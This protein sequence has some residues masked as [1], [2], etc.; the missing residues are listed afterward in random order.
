MK[1]KN[2]YS[3]V[4]QKTAN[5]DL[6]YVSY[7]HN[8]NY[9]NFWFSVAFDKKGE[10]CS[11]STMQKMVSDTGDFYVNDIAGN[12]TEREFN[13]ALFKT[14]AFMIKR[15]YSIFVHNNFIEK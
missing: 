10:V 11:I 2:K 13:E 5:S 4:V 12:I 6:E 8:S 7:Y 14:M 9:M 1:E 15:N 3:K